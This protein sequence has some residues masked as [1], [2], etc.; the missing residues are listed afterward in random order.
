MTTLVTGGT[1][2]I[3]L[4]IALKLARPGETLAL[5]YHSDSKA[6]ETAVA[7]LIA[8]GASAQA[9]VTD[10][11]DIEAVNSLMTQVG[12]LGGGP[13]HIVHSAA[14]IWPTSLLEADPRRFTQAMQTNGLSLLY[15]VQAALPQ[16]A[17]GS[18]IVFISSAGARQ[19]QV[20]YGALG[21]GKALAESLIRYL[22]PELAPRGVRINAVS[23][24][25]V[26]TSS[27]AQMLGSQSAAEKLYERAARSNP[28][29]RMTADDDYSAMVEFLL[30]PAAQ[31]IQ[32]QVIQVN[33]GA[34]VG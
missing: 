13:L 3:G 25:L 5:A 27:V 16:L 33:G 19:S 11:G 31:F 6:A 12:D 26:Q 14:A 22:V 28:S 4:A 10:V 21:V 9:F 8:K 17:D 32:G 18:S 7:S 1:K 15:L 23:P 29:G 24:G 30:S 20:G 34:F 2:G